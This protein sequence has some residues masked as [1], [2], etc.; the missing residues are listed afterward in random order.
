M[1]IASGKTCKIEKVHYNSNHETKRK[2]WRKYYAVNEKTSNRN[3]RY[4]A[5]RD[6]DP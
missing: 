3:E 2:L 6:A 1:I 5:C 4:H